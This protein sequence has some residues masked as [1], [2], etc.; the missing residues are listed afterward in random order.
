MGEE[1]RVWNAEGR[2]VSG[3]S[4]ADAP[5]SEWV[6]GL[7]RIARYLGRKPSSVRASLL[8]GTIPA[9]DFDGELCVRRTVL[10]EIV[11]K[12]ARRP[13]HGR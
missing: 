10:A 6:C 9:K 2:P 11:R 4:A 13:R 5:P 8:A 12:S 1:P 7:D 3:P